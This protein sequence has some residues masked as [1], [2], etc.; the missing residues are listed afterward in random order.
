MGLSQAPKPRINPILQ[1]RLN[2]QSMKK[3]INTFFRWNK[4]R[5]EHKREET[6]KK[7]YGCISSYFEIM[8]FEG[9][10]YLTCHGTPFQHLSSNITTSDIKNRLED[11][12]KAALHYFNQK[13]ADLNTLGR[14]NSTDPSR[15]I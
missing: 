14:K 13:N 2:N 12:R 11:A 3:I 8:E 15:I 10:I 6:D 9:E 7:I 1:I 4:S 5:K